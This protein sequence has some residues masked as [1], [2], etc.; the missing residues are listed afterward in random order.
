M[1][2]NARAPFASTAFLTVVVGCGQSSN[3]P[4]P[5]PADSKPDVTVTFDAQRRKC[6]VALSTEAQGSTI[7]CPEVVAF[8]K[9]ELRLPQGSAYGLRTPAGADAA[10]VATVRAALNGAGYRFIEDKK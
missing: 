7:P 4:M 6:V 2:I 5:S 10:E 3:T 9:E 8:V 1:K